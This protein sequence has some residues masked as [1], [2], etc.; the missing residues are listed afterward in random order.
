[1]DEFSINAMKE[2]LSQIENNKT[3]K[4]V[5]RLEDKNV[6]GVKWIFRN[7]L[8]ENRKMSRNKDRLV[9]KGYA[10]IKGVD[11]DE[12]F[13]LVVRI[14]AIRTFLAYSAFKGFKMYQM[15]VKMKFL[16]GYLDEDIYMDHLTNLK[17]KSI[18]IMSIG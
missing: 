14:E 2:E 8:D 9:C 12:T 1:M 3:W 5:L 16:N 10:Q 11:F 17:T 13:A 4:L 18:L 6:I 7:K 15:D